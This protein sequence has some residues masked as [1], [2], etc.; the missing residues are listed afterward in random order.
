MKQG[1]LVRGIRGISAVGAGPRL[2]GQ[3]KWW[4]P[5]TIQLHLSAFLAISFKNTNRVPTSS[6]LNKLPYLFAR[7]YSSLPSP[8]PSPSSGIA[9][10]FPFSGERRAWEIK[11]FLKMAVSRVPFGAFVLVSLVFFLVLPAIQA[12]S[13][14]PAPAP[15]SDGESSPFF[16]SSLFPR[17]RRQI[18]V[19]FFIFYSFLF[20]TWICSCIVEIS[21]LF[22]EISCILRPDLVISREVLWICRWMRFPWC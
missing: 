18:Y 15:T 7:D 11:R 20:R 21:G 22:R 10:N 16:R 2:F 8:S 6:F 19:F 3:N 1:F 14:P 13:L 9:D 17:F 12:Q 5:P 4:T